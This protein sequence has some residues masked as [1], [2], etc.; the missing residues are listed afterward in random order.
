MGVVVYLYGAFIDL[1]VKKCNFTKNEAVFYC[2]AIYSKNVTGKVVVQQCLFANNWDS[3]YLIGIH[4]QLMDCEFFCDPS[5]PCQMPEFSAVNIQFGASSINNCTFR[6]EFGVSINAFGTK[7][8]IT[9]SKWYGYG[10]H[11]YCLDL[12]NSKITIVGSNFDADAMVVLNNDNWSNLTVINTSFVNGNRVN[13]HV[14][15]S[16]RGTDRVEFI[17][18]LFHSCGGLVQIG[19]TLLKNCTISNYQEPFI[20]SGL[21]D[22]TISAKLEI[23]DCII[24]GNN[25]AGYQP[26]IYLENASFTMIN[27]LYAGNDA[28]NHFFLN[29][30]TDVTIKNVTFFNIS[31]GENGDPRNENSLLFVNNTVMKMKNCNFESNNL[32]S[33]SLMLVLGSKVRVINTIMS[34][35]YKKISTQRKLISTHD[36]QTVEFSSSKFINNYEIDIFVVRSSNLLFIDN[37]LFENSDA[38]GDFI[39]Q[40]TYDVIIQRSRFHDLLL[41][42]IKDVNNLRIFRCTCTPD[43]YNFFIEGILKTRVF[44]LDSNVSIDGPDTTIVIEESPYAS[45]GY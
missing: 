38:F 19:Q 4:S 40:N 31:F 13:G 24:M 15:N 35:N 8:N 26:F 34:D 28:R 1:F 29:V 9:D 25:V 41:D 14:F 44:L 39:I 5:L 3:L 22:P 7:L 12:D 27:C 16:V 37:C 43:G 6:D 21:A 2:S 18:C 11:K 33:G 17:N 42:Y 20:Q 45:G 32:Q 10:F 36:S 23:L 30:T